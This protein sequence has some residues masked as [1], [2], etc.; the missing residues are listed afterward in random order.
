MS[1]ACG[2]DA[3]IRPTGTIGNE[4]FSANAFMAADWPGVTGGRFEVQAWPTSMV[5]SPTDL[6][7]SVIQSSGE[8]RCD[9]G[10][11]SGFFEVIDDRAPGEEG[12]RIIVDVPLLDSEVETYVS[13]LGHMVTELAL[14]EAENNGLRLTDAIVRAQERLQPA[15]LDVAYPHV[16]PRRSSSPPETDAERIGF[17]LT[18]LVRIVR[19]DYG[20]LPTFYKTRVVARELAT[21][22]RRYGEFR[23][24]VLTSA[25]GTVTI[26]RE[27]LRHD[28]A[29]ETLEQA[30]SWGLSREQA[31]AIA[32]RIN[33]QSGP[34]FGFSQAPPL[35]R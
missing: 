33:G 4:L 12:L 28:L 17:V 16:S 32:R 20:V 18:A 2:V 21:T 13:P 6:C 23:P 22:L 27:L 34:L 30:E 29:L 10:A 3:P 31:G 7:L 35:P 25:S 9:L 14:Y 19:R 5:D 24:V 1:S 15:L 11:L 8:W 26:S